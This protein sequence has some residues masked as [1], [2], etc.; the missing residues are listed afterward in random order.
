MTV[1]QA[2]CLSVTSAKVAVECL[3]SLLWEEM[4]EGFWRV[5]PEP[6]WF[7]MQGKLHARPALT[8]MF[9]FDSLPPPVW[10]N[11]CVSQAFRHKRSSGSYAKGDWPRSHLLL[12]LLTFANREQLEGSGGK[13]GACLTFSELTIII[14]CVALAAEAICIS[15]SSYENCVFILCSDALQTYCASL[16]NIITNLIKLGLKIRALTKI[17]RVQS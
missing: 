4:Q 11:L 8:A 12:C 2:T 13:K 1:E 16:Q 14:S 9:S 3:N 6:G 15:L 10:L 17:L 7:C 5:N